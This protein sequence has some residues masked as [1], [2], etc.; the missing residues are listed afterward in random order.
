MFTLFV[1]V[2]DIEKPML[3]S[4]F[5]YFSSQRPLGIINSVQIFVGQ[6]QRVR[7]G[8]KEERGLLARREE[9]PTKLGALLAINS[10]AVHTVL[11][12]ACALIANHNS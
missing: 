2:S 3:T 12:V 4:Y 7:G 11:L 10:P 8:G 5:V 1:V 6:I 9:T